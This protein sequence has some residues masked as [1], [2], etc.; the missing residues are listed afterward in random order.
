[1]FERIVINPFLMFKK[2]HIYGEI[3]LYLY[4]HPQNRCSL[5]DIGENISKSTNSYLLDVID[6]LISDELIIREKFQVK[7]SDPPM[8]YINVY[9]ISYTGFTFIKD[10]KEKRNSTIFNSISIGFACLSVIIASYICFGNN[11]KITKVEITKF[12]YLKNST[13]DTAT[14]INKP[15]KIA[16][17]IIGKSCLVH[18]NP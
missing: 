3:L 2:G 8:Q 12:P 11:N 18:G 5:R 14:P 6:W 7:D 10:L 16:A 4:E 13:H 17:K 9:R 15:Y 1:M